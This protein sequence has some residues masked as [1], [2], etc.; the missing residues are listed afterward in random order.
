[1]KIRLLCSFSLSLLLAACGQSGSL[2][3]PDDKPP[4]PPPAVAQPAEVVDVPAAPA[5]EPP[6]PAVAQP[7]NPASSS[8]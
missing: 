8:P 3:L 6:P 4:P 7:K 1:M 2:Y 5:A